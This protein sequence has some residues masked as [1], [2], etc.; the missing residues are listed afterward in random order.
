VIDQN[1]GYRFTMPGGDGNPPQLILAFVPEPSGVVLAIL[2]GVMG[3]A[4]RYKF[5]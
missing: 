3:L 2:A 5:T 1:W 4:N